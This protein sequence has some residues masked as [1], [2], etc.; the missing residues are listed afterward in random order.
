ML[1]SYPDELHVA[2]S[3]MMSCLFGGGGGGG[4]GDNYAR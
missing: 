4:G 2:L 1:I 3:L